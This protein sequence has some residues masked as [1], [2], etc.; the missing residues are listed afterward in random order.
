MVPHPST[1][2]IHYP[3]LTRIR[4]E[5][6][7]TE[8][9]PSSGFQEA[10]DAGT[11]DELPAHALFARWNR[12]VYDAFSFSLSYLIADWTSLKSTSFHNVVNQAVP[13][14]PRGSTEAWFEHC[15]CG[16]P[17]FTYGWPGI[18]CPDHVDE[19]RRAKMIIDL[20]SSVEAEKEGGIYLH[21]VGK[22]HGVGGEV[23]KGK[24]VRVSVEK[25]CPLIV[26]SLEDQHKLLF[27][28]G[29]E[30]RARELVGETAWKYRKWL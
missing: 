18:D 5:E 24:A 16:T 19:R 26:R 29:G 25:T 9:S 2:T 4:R 27:V 23:E 22:L 8:H 11:Y 6:W 10:L 21:G 7:F 28:S 15:Q 3:S 20:L 1:V 17:E 12:F 14:P 13:L 30:E